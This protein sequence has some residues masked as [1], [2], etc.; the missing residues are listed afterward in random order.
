MVNRRYVSEFFCQVLDLNHWGHCYTMRAE[1]D[2][3]TKQGNKIN[4][5]SHKI[6]VCFSWS[7]TSARVLV[8]QV[9]ELGDSKH[10]D[11]R[12]LDPLLSFVPRATSKGN[13]MWVVFGQS[14]QRRLSTVNVAAFTG[15]N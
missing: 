13:R 7:T 1:P 11:T 3:M 2:R 14:S 4:C 8:A 12:P 6:V 5:P 15:L 10:Q 9:S